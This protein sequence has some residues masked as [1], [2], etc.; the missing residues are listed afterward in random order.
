MPFVSC[1]E[2]T[3]CGKQLDARKV[4]NLCECGGPL[5]VRYELDRVAARRMR[6]RLASRPATLWRYWEVLPLYRESAVVSLGEGFTPL[7]HAERLGGKLGLKSL[8]LKDE[9]DR[10]S[11]RL[12]S[13]HLVISYAVFC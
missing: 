4:C 3:R 9:S 8:Y 11:T 5:F 2:C 6:E 12:N 13:S 10:K 7:I 1:L